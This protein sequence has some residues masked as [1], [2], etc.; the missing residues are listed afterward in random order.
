MEAFVDAYRPDRTLLVGGDGIA[1]DRF[2][3]TPMEHWLQR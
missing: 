2:L 3:S 1:L